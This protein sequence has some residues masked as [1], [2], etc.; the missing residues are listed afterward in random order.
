MQES[1]SQLA[2]MRIKDEKEEPRKLPEM[3]STAAATA[4]A[5]VFCY[6]INDFL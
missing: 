4:T 1:A 5:A 3:T 6:L 2:M